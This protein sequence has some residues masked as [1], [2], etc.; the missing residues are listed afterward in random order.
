[1][2]ENAKITNRNQSCNPKKKN[3]NKTKMTVWQYNNLLIKKSLDK[4]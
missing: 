4:E 3:K 2:Y 1:M